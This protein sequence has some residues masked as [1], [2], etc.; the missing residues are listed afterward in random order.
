MKRLRLPK[1]RRT[2]DAS[3]TAPAEAPFEAQSLF[4]YFPALES[5]K[6]KR[7]AEEMSL[8]HFKRGNRVLGDLQSR[9]DILLVLK[10]AIAVTW[11]RDSGHQLLV[12]LLAPGEMFGVSSS[13]LPEL[14]QGLRGYAFIN[15]LVAT[16]DSRRLLDILLGVDLEAF[17][18]ATEMTMGWSFNTLMRYIRMFHL[19]P[20]DRLVIAL[21]EMGAKFGVRDSRG[22]I[23]NLPIS[24]KDLANLLGASRQTVNADLGH[25]LRLGAVVNLHRPIVLVP[26]KLFALIDASGIYH[27][28]APNRHLRPKSRQPSINPPRKTGVLSMKQM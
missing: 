4:K 17:K 23:V 6:L 25:L 28:S 16:I 8:A 3:S 5:Y 26:E 1:K 19:L 2:S 12:T 11:Q 10:G 21:I 13:L 20:R 14:A 15:S 27:P 9:T 22:L 18:A 24:Q 7:L